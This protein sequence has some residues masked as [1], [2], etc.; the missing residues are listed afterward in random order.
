MWQ[1]N[2]TRLFLLNKEVN[3]AKEISGLFSDYLVSCGDCR[4]K[5]LNDMKSARAFLGEVSLLFTFS[6]AFDKMELSFNSWPFVQAVT[7]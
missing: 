6:H 2:H 3:D 1:S 7:K 5:D 4:A